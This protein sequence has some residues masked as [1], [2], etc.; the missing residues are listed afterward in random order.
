[1]DKVLLGHSCMTVQINYLNDLQQQGEKIFSISSKLTMLL[2]HINAERFMSRYTCPS[3][4]CL[5][6]KRYL[7][8]SL[9]VRLDP[10]TVLF[11]LRLTRNLYILSVFTSLH[12]VIRCKLLETFNSMSCYGFKLTVLISPSVDPFQANKGGSFPSTRHID[13]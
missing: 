12:K 6:N 11:S 8:K 13:S 5:E 4:L 10:W 3:P 9:Q 7:K 1:M 2:L